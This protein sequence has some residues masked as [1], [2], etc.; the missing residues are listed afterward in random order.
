MGGAGW[1]AMTDDNQRWFLICRGDKERIGGRV[2][3]SVRGQAIFGRICK[4]LRHRKERRGNLRPRTDPHGGD[5]AALWVQ[6]KE[7]RGRRGAAADQPELA[8]IGVKPFQRIVSA[9]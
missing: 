5:G 2:K 1:P 3:D 6:R 7:R 4:R 8:A 9:R